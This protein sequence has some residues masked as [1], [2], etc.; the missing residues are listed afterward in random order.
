MPQIEYPPVKKNL[1]PKSPLRNT[2]IM[3][4]KCEQL[5]KNYFVDFEMEPTYQ[6]F[7]EFPGGDG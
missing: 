4:I 3:N 2:T 1:H 5:Y 7:A 6:A